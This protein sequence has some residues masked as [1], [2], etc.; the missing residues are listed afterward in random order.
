MVTLDL[1]K[2]YRKKAGVIQD[3]VS[4]VQREWRE[5]EQSA[6]TAAKA[7]RCSKQQQKGERLWAG[8]ARV[9]ATSIQ[10]RL[11]DGRGRRSVEI[12]RV[13]HA[14][15]ATLIL[16]QPFYHFGLPEARRRYY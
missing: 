11:L 8:V 3:R 6:H 15:G 13:E 14:G 12:G 16:G 2:Q 4:A 5:F 9:H 10:G 7:D 1:H